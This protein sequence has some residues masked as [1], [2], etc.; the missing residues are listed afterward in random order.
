MSW[1]TPQLAEREGKGARVARPGS[2]AG[3]HA[4]RQAHQGQFFTPEA[5]CNAIWALLGPVLGTAPKEWPLSILDNSLGTG[6]LLQNAV[7]G[8]HALYGVDPDGES[9]EALA[10]AALDAGFKREFLP[11]GLEDINPRGFDL[12]LLNPP[13]SLT[14]QSPHLYPYPCT[15]WGRFGRNTAAL[16]HEY[17]LAQAL[18]ACRV[19]VA[20]LP[21]SFA[22]ASA[23]TDNPR[24]AAV[25]ELPRGAFER[26]GAASV[27][28][29]I[30]VFDELPR[31][32]PAV[33]VDRAVSLGLALEDPKV[34]SWWRELGQSL[35]LTFS[36][37]TRQSYH[38]ELRPRHIRPTK[39]VITRPV[40]HNARVDVAHNGRRIVLGFHCGLVEAKVLN[41]LYRGLA[42]AVDPKR[43][44]PAGI[45]YRGQLKLDLEFHLA[46]DDPK[47]SFRALLAT[48]QSAGG[49]PVVERSL[50]GYFKRRLKELERSREPFLR[51]V[52]IPAERKG[53][54]DTVSARALNPTPL[55][56]DR[57]DSPL[58]PAGT[59]LEFKVDGTTETPSYELS[60]RDHE[61]CYSE[62]EFKRLFVRSGSLEHRRTGEP[63]W[64]K[65][66]DGKAARFTE[67]AGLIRSQAVAKGLDRILSWPYQ[68]DDLIELS[69]CPG[70]AALGWDPSLGKSR[71]SAG[72]CLLG[73]RHNLVVVEAGLQ[74]EMAI[75]L[76]K[77]GLDTSLYQFLTCPSQLESLRRINIISYERLR[78]PVCRGAGRRTWAR[79]LRRRLHTVVCDEADHLSHRDSAQTKAVWMLSPKRR[80]ALAGEPLPNYPRDLLPVL[81]WAT[82]NATAAQP[83][84]YRRPFVSGDRATI[85]EASLAVRGIDRFRDDFLTYEWITHQHSEHLTTGAKR[86]IPKIKDLQGFRSFHAPHM[87]RRVVHEPDCE[88]YAGSPVPREITRTIGWDIDHLDHYL[89]VAENFASWYQSETAGDRRVSLVRVLAKIGAVFA[90]ANN[91]FSPAPHCPAYH[92]ES[93][94]F[95]AAVDRLEWL[96]EHGHKTILYAKSPKLLERMAR[97]L[98]DRGIESTTFHGGKNAK[99]RMRDL[100]NEFRFGPKPV[101][102]ASLGVTQKGLNLPQA[103]RVILFNRSWSSKAERQAIKRVLRSAQMRRV[104]VEY[105]HLEGSIDEYQA[106]MVAF[107]QDATDAGVDW[108]ESEFEAADFVHLDTILARFVEDLPGLKAHRDSLREQQRLAA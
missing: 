107:K 93:S 76:K 5:I 49:D 101:L 21:G 60:Y 2:L 33:R 17:A 45:R 77:M 100:D 3:L 83:Y 74:G 61:V 16:S 4:A 15:H 91:P 106:Q 80:Y 41:G 31:P 63:A 57:W 25:I 55:Y 42:E 8:R 18:Q 108:Q 86:E 46:Q 82:E 50:Q 58:I 52:R 92:G 23:V 24:L 81:C 20:V 34:A 104:L 95:E 64:V 13:F 79:M 6:R 28:T 29:A 88:P 30:A 40:T 89:D 96:A 97:A 51:W 75:E 47:A 65:I 69:I 26:S 67:M 66:H 102:L 37:D 7:P 48:I 43:R 12:G 59:D 68:M 71:I 56:A 72:L 32:R 84:G 19:V 35:G 38:P 9:V 54:G 99:Q 78:S 70:G 44:L 62:S 14:L 10:A 73:G 94:K 105:L 22:K 1:Y 39:P 36:S 103:N 98:A 11:V 87:L 53:D 90:A 85:E 27:D